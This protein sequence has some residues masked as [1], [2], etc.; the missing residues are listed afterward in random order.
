M[1][2]DVNQAKRVWFLRHRVEGGKTID[3]RTFM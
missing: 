3:R 1:Y 2:V